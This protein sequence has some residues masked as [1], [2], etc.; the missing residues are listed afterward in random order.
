[1][2]FNKNAFLKIF[3]LAALLPLKSLAAEDISTPLVEYFDCLRLVIP[4][5]DLPVFMKT[6]KQ[7]SEKPTS[8]YYK[9]VKIQ[10]RTGA[11]GKVI[12]A[13]EFGDSDVSLDELKEGIRFGV[14]GKVLH[15]VEA[16]KDFDPQK[17]GR[18]IIGFLTEIPMG[19]IIVNTIKG[20]PDP[21]YLEVKSKEVGLSKSLKSYYDQQKLGRWK[22][23]EF[24]VMKR[25]DHWIAVDQKGDK[26]D[27]LFVEMNFLNPFIP[28]IKGLDS[29]R[30]LNS[31]KGFQCWNVRSPEFAQ[32]SLSNEIRA[33]NATSKLDCY[34]GEKPI[35]PQDDYTE[36]FGL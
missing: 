21:A 14:S 36:Y 13:V 5:P 3:L 19:E 8:V 35:N 10:T 30:G 20:N 25:N 2:I 18:L 31:N 4:P 6:S 22:E 11:D 23:F 28:M 17:G 24:Q 27:T 33:G 1:M 12:K 32:E 26:I 34:N 15:T 29:M 9:G 7:I 16:A